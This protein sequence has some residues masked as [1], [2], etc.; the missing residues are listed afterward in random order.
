MSKENQSGYMME[1]AKLDVLDKLAKLSTPTLVIL[2]RGDQVNWFED[3][4]DLTTLIRG[5]HF[6][7]LESR[8]HILLEDE[9]AWNDFLVETRR[10]P[11]VKRAG[12]EPHSKAKELGLK[13]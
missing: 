9:P 4:R 8:N 2:T 12:P 1:F 6:I 13:T 11:G 5:A 10:L 3:R 7:P